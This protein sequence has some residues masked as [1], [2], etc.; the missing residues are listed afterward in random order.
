MSF[1][2][3]LA[4]Q[5]GLARLMAMLGPTLPIGGSSFRKSSGRRR[6]K[7]RTGLNPP[8][9]SGWWRRNADLAPVLITERMLMRHG[10]YRRQ[11]RKQGVAIDLNA[12][13]SVRL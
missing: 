10:W 4:G 9:R 8:N 7:A 1:I 2:N 13:N 6:W 3:L 12:K 5:F 11:L